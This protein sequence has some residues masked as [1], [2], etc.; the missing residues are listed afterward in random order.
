MCWMSNNIEIKTAKENIS[1]WKVVYKINNAPERCR[2]YY[3]KY[4]Y[5]KNYYEYTPMCITILSDGHIQGDKGFH[6]YSNDLEGIYTIKGIDVTMKGKLFIESVILA[7]YLNDPDLKMA[8][9]IIP[10]GA[11][12]MKN[13][14]GEIMSDTI[15]FDGFID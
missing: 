5:A 12:Y 14:V 6:S 13:E 3:T 8:R 15:I 9:F 2:S 11:Q 1:V 10:K 4:N 7:H